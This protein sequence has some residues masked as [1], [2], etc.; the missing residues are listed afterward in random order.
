[1]HKLFNVYLYQTDIS[2]VVTFS[3]IAP[4][5]EHVPQRKKGMLLHVV[6]ILDN[7]FFPCAT[8]CPESLQNL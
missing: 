8:H 4:L 1:M 2:Q 5:G 6:T 7:L 3:F